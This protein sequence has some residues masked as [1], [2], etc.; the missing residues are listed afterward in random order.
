MLPNGIGIFHRSLCSDVSIPQSPVNWHAGGS[1]VNL[2]LHKWVLIN[3]IKNLRLQ[4]TY[5]SAPSMVKQGAHLR[6][7]VLS[8]TPCF[9]GGL[10]ANCTS[11]NRFNFNGLHAERR[12]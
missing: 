3:T 6:C 7:L 4:H 9:N 8:L 11:V 1:Q 10:R 2:L 5:S 12:L